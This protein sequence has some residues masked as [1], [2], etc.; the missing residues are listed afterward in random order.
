MI[1]DTLTKREKEVLDYIMWGL[2]SDEI[3]RLLYLSYG[4]ISAI[5][6]NLYDKYNIDSKPFRV[7]LI[8]KRFKELGI[9]TR[10]LTATKAVF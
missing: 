4:R 6:Y 3:A 10:D 9:D 5:T 7:K 1:Y 8:L 2:S